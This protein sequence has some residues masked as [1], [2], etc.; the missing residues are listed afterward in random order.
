MKFLSLRDAIEMSGFKLPQLLNEPVEKPSRKP[1]R[2]LIAGGSIRWKPVDISAAKLLMKSPWFFHPP[3]TRPS[4]V[5]LASKNKHKSKHKNTMKVDYPEKL[6][7]TPVEGGDY[8]SDVGLHV[9]MVNGQP[10]FK[11]SEIQQIVF[12]ECDRMAKETS[13]I[14]RQAQDARRIVD[15]LVHG[16]GGDMERF[17]A[18]VRIHLEDIRQARMAI[19]TETSQMSGP[20]KEVRQFFLGADYKDQ[21]ARLTEFVNLCERLQKLKDCGFLDRVADTLI[22]LS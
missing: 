7:T 10:M 3:P 18:S 12:A 1:H 6:T 9:H 15:E 5:S 16:I 21:I 8:V 14:V 2:E 17:K 11:R 19:V 4:T 22:R 13:P 20:L